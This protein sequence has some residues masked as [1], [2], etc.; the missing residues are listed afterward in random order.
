MLT[1]K[2]TP[3][4]LEYQVFD[5]SSCH[6]PRP[7]VSVLPRF[8]PAFGYDYQSNSFSSM[9][10]GQGEY[11]SKGRYALGEACRRSGLDGKGVL[12]APAY[13]CVTMLDPALSLGAEVLFYPLTQDLA[14]EMGALDILLERTSKPVKALL[15]THFF[16]FVRDFSPIKQWCVAH[17][18]QLIEDC[19]HTL[20]TEHYQANWAGLYGDYVV[21]SP[22]KFFPVADG[23]WLYAP[24]A[25]A[26]SDVAPKP[27][28][29]RDELRGIKHCVE[30]V[31]QP[32]IGP[33]EIA[34]LDEQ[35]SSLAGMPP[36]AGV[37][38]RISRLAHS[39]QYKPDRENISALRGS[40]W[41]INHTSVAAIVSQRQANYRRW[42]DAVADL[43]G[44]HPL[45]SELPA[46][47]VP[48]MFPLY[49]DQPM[50]HFFWL[51][52]LAVP[53]WRWD[54]MAI[55][56]CPVAQNYRLHLLHLPCHQS[57]REYEMDWLV[58]ALTKVVRSSSTGG[59]K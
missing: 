34:L 42:L 12:L 27:A 33:D 48:Y 13:H 1:P 56:G 51:K 35:L 45:Y 3:V 41:L 59:A 9:S 58:A 5:P 40:R 52:Q 10:A 19:S 47:V 39:S 21:S 36:E 18:I 6:F 14:P 38:Q 31:R 17:G 29:W 25:S 22:Y 28:T 23:G 44:C 37:D 20:F 32:R 4:P 7:L 55:S 46:H 24:S 16:G 53:V 43:P 15:V 8:E 26:L 11:Y 57:L 30:T 54:E 50:P 49:L 2:V